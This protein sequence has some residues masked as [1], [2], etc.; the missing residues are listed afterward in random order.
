MYEGLH[1]G[2]FGDEYLVMAPFSSKACMLEVDTLAHS[3]NFFSMPSFWAL[4]IFSGVMVT[5]KCTV[6]SVW[7]SL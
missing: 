5:I 2:L 4:A 1:D 3:L 6:V 7:C